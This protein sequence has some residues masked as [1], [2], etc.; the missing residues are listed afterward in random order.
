MH[1]ST[2]ADLVKRVLDDALLDAML[3]EVDEANLLE[4]LDDFLGRL[5]FLRGRTRLNKLAEVYQRDFE[6]RSLSRHD[7]LHDL[8][9]RRVLLLTSATVAYALQARV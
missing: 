3:I 4:A 6:R 5:A 7:W 9:T 2:A 1:T 8:N